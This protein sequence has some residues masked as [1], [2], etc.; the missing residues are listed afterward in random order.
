MKEQEIRKIIDDF[1]LAEEQMDILRQNAY[2]VG[3]DVASFRG[4][5]YPSLS[6][7]FPSEEYNG[8]S[9]SKVDITIE[10]QEYHCGEDDFYH[11]NFPLF[12][13]W[14]DWK[15]VE[16]LRLEKEKIEKKTQKKERQNKKEKTKRKKR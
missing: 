7:V 11:F 13:L 14:E 16:E 2:Y 12:Y 9:I 4:K 6:N 3:R 5:D 1:Y 8:I 10:W 15:K